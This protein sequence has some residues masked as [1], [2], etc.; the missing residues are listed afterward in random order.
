MKHFTINLKKEYKMLQTNQ[1]PTLTAYI[2]DNYNDIDIN[3]KRKTIIICP[4]GGYQGCS[5]REAEPVALH[6]LGK[7]F[8]AFY[9]KYSIA[10]EKYP[11]SLCE[12]FASIDYIR[13]NSEQFNVDVN[14][15][16]VLGFSAGAHLADCGANFYIN[17][18]F[19]DF[20][21]TTVENLKIN[22]SVLCYGVITSGKYAHFGSFENLTGNDNSLK[23]KLSLEHTVG[24]QTP[25]TYL[26]HTAN[27]D[28]V[29]VENSLLY[30]TALSRYKIPYTLKIFTNGV[31]GLSLAD[32]R[33]TNANNHY[34]INNDVQIWAYDCVNWL[35]KV[36][37]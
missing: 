9:L 10:P 32:I 14:K 25:P 37:D 1:Y 12:L 7:N 20:L 23:E 28:C 15:I 36:L 6:F 16:A 27:D 3:R 5:D 33:T 4:G 13:H 26:W 21:G 31:H 2:P 29:P 18:E 11:C 19:A 17:K 35:D 34:L 30:A 8:N 22:A 24:Q